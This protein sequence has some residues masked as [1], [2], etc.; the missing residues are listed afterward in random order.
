[1][2]HLSLHHLHHPW[3]GALSYWYS[4]GLVLER[5]NKPS[6]QIGSGL[7]VCRASAE[8]GRQGSNWLRFLATEPELGTHNL[9][10]RPQVPQENARTVISSMVVSRAA[11]CFLTYSLQSPLSPTLGTLFL[12]VL[13][14]LAS[15]LL[16]L[17]F[18]LRSHHPWRMPL[19]CSSLPAASFILWGLMVGVEM[20][21]SNGG[22]ESPRSLCTTGSHFGRKILQCFSSCL[23]PWVTYFILPFLTFFYYLRYY[24]LQHGE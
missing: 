21:C 7:K 2:A 4:P 19:A 18:S 14:N 9:P 10:R 22:C 13:G 15:F 5:A 23:F 1:M 6:K 24:D 3:L 17:H 16:Y 11:T 20:L 8:W 12:S